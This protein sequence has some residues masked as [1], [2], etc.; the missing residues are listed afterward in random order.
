MFAVMTDCTLMRRPTVLL[1]TVVCLV[2]FAASRLLA[3]EMMFYVYN[4]PESPQDTRYQY[5]WEIL[6]TAL[7]KTKEKYGPYRMVASELMTEQRQAFELKHAT[8][9]ITVMYLSTVPDFETNLVP[10]R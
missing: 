3:G 6:R 4:A 8:G 7:E 2:L 9:K 1:T 10:I 5:H